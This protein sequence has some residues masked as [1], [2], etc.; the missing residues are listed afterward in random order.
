MGFKTIWPELGR[1]IVGE[2]GHYFTQIVDKKT[3]RGKHLLITSGGINHMA[4]PALTG[5][6]FPAQLFRE[7]HARER[8]YTIHGPLC[9]ALD[10]LGTFSLPEDAAPGDWIVFSAAG[11]YGLTESMPF[12][13]GH[14]LPAE[15]ISYKGD[16]MIPRTVKTNSDWSV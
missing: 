12:F 9:T 3:V 4:R 7:S 5:E 15:V 10:K 1:Y 8:K 11:A 16:M 2:S 6:S 14:D 13:L